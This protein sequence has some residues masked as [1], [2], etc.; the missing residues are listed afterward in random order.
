MSIIENCYALSFSEFPTSYHF[1]NNRSALKHRTFVSDAIKELL[2]ND[3]IKECQ[4]PQGYWLFTWD[5][6][7]GY[8]HVD[9]F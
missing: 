8:H 1:R 7:S 2:K 4:S 3:C 9:I 5:L 6:K